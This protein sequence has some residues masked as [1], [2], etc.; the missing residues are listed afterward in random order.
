MADMIGME[1][2]P[3]RVAPRVLN[4]EETVTLARPPRFAHSS[5]ATRP[6]PRQEIHAVCISEISAL[7]ATLKIILHQRNNSWRCHAK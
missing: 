2:N 7:P 6:A 3:A 5:F 1:A 4:V